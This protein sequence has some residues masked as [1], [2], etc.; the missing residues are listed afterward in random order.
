MG[1]FRESLE[2]SLEAAIQ[3]DQLDED[4]HA[5]IISAA[6][7]LASQLDATEEPRASA[8]ATYLT[9][10]KT[11]GIVPLQQSQTSVV[12]GA[13]KVA[14]IRAHSRAGLRAV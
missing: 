8:F 2:V 3:L 7:A 9:Y 6:R 5:A 12:V 1:P 4:R 14:K 13:G 10:C 11:L